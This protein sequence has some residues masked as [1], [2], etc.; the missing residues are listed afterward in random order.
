MK[1]NEIESRSQLQEI[2]LGSL[3]ARG[4]GA[5]KG[6]ISAAKTVL[7][8]PAV[9]DFAR[10][11]GNELMS[12]YTGVDKPGGQDWFKATEPPQETAPARQRMAKAI[13]DQ[14]GNTVAQVK[15][16]TKT[17]SGVGVNDFKL[18]DKRQLSMAANMLIS[19]L[20]PKLT[21]GMVQNIDDVVNL[22][23]SD[24]ITK[25]ADPLQA[26]GYVLRIDRKLR[27][28]INALM[29][30]DPSTDAGKTDIKKHWQN[31][32]NSAELLTQLKN[33][34]PAAMYG[35]AG[36][37]IARDASGRITVDGK[38]ADA[39][40]RAAIAAQGLEPPAA[41]APAPAPGTP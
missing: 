39:E 16:N 15:A 7:A 22:K 6:G 9:K 20:L 12:R 14:W 2:A 25:S 32:V 5:V 19:Q 31:V 27:T 33:L 4:V 10:G 13:A 30:A 35:L 21:G 26:S 41:P 38:L 37:K 29:V 11:V 3:L 40:T 1:I 17:D 18:I 23:N 8:N 24:L 34:K 36:K 28:A